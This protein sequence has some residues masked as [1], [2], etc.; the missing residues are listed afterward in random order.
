[1][2]NVPQTALSSY[3]SILCYGW[4]VRSSAFGGIVNLTLLCLC[5]CSSTWQGGGA[6]EDSII[7][8]DFASI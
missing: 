6:S 3:L 5:D 1:M 2:F 7:I 8:L 4:A